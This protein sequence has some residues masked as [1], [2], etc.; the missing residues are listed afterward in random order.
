M[1]KPFKERFIVR[2]SDLKTADNLKLLSPYLENRRT[3]Q[4]QNS[5]AHVLYNEVIITFIT[6][7]S[8]WFTVIPYNSGATF[9]LRKYVLLRNWI[10][11]ILIIRKFFLI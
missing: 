4:I 5:E 8:I 2:M 10:P 3:L 1:L 9:I 11:K 6:I 7:F